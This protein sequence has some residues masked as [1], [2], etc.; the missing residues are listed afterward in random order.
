M[1]SIFSR[2]TIELLVSDFYKDILCRPPDPTGLSNWVN[3][4]IR[5]GGGSDALASILEFFVNSEEYK[6]LPIRNLPAFEHPAQN[7]KKKIAIFG[8]SDESRLVFLLLAHKPEGIDVNC[9]IDDNDM[10]SFCG[11]PVKKADKLDPYIDNILITNTYSASGHFFDQIDFDK[12]KSRL[13]TFDIKKFFFILPNPANGRIDSPQWAP[14]LG[15]EVVVFGSCK[16]GIRLAELVKDLSNVFEDA[17]ENTIQIMCIVDSIEE[18][19]EVPLVGHKMLIAKDEYVDAFSDL[20][21]LGVL[22]E[23]IYIVKF[24]DSQIKLVDQF[25]RDGDIL[26]Y[27]MTKVGTITFSESLK[28]IGIRTIVTHFLAPKPLNRLS[29]INFIDPDDE[30]LWTILNNWTWMVDTVYICKYLQKHLHKKLHVITGVR[31]PL[32]QLL[33]SFFQRFEAKCQYGL[34]NIPSHPDFLYSE[35]RD[36]IMQRFILGDWFDYELKANLQIDVY[37]QPF[38]SSKGYQIIE[39]NNIRLLIIR[40]ENLDDVWA[41]AVTEWLGTERVSG[42]DLTLNRANEAS[43][44]STANLYKEAKS[45]IKFNQK[46]IEDI[47]ETQYVKHFYSPEELDR[48]KQKW[49]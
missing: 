3:H 26:V 24:T 45:S 46:L 30:V 28:Q 25:M 8:T 32:D 5:L 49:L 16:T 11:L 29:Q 10:E 27:T 19:A 6:N 34:R 44:R 2:E 4:A 20:L 12:E 42:M 22:P 33:S 7:S 38:D 9:F 43:T 15:K 48:F 1:K 31:N 47:Y 40:L 35:I 17:F 14:L 13:V 21:A 41:R 39:E 23:D 36:F 37:K 18:L